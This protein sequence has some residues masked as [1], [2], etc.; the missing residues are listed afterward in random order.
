MGDL[1]FKCSRIVALIWRIVAHV[2]IEVTIGVLGGA[3]GPVDI[4]AKTRRVVVAI[5]RISQDRLPQIWQMPG[6][7]GNR[8]SLGV[9]SLDDRQLK[10]LG[11]L[12]SAAEA[13][14]AISLARDIFPRLSFDLIYARPGQQLDQWKQELTAAIELAAD[15]LS[16][17][18]LTIEQGTPFFDLHRRGKIV[19]PEPEQAAQLYEL[20]QE[21][22]EVH[23]LPA[24]EISNH[25]RP[26]S[27]SRH[28][29]TYWRFGNWVGVGPGAHGRLTMNDGRHATSTLRHPE[30][31]LQQV[32]SDGH[33][34]TEN[35][36]LTHEDAADE[37]LLM[38]LR[39]REGMDIGRYELEW[40]KALDPQRLDHL[41]ELGMV[42]MFGSNRIRATAEGWLVLDA[43][44]ADL[45]A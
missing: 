21:V 6:R 42:E 41:L 17:Y 28:N 12:H 33:G 2:G 16:L 30:G 9:Q 7:G 1:C 43:V 32:Q 27:E 10:F 29:L 5:E 44:I 20:T 18:Q 3:E 34:L 4:D 8:V 13:R 45:A 39:L 38:G 24:Y 19:V 15:H 40:D 35:E 26:G 25:A 11:R 36:L 14:A 31:W 37:M 23:G 22:T